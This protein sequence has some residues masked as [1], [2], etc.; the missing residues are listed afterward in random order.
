MALNPSGPISLGGATTGQSI[1]LELA[2]SPTGVI[3]LNQTDVRTLAGAASGTIS[4][5][6]FYGKSS[7]V[8]LYLR[9][10]SASSMAISPDKSRI[11]YFTTPTTTT[12]AVYVFNTSDFSLVYAKTATLHIITATGSQGIYGVT[13]AFDDSNNLFLAKGTYNGG[14]GISFVLYNS[15]G[16]LVASRSISNTGTNGVST[17][18]YANGFFYTAGRINNQGRL[19]KSSS[20]TLALSA[21][22]L[23][24]R[25]RVH[26][27][28]VAS[29]DRAYSIID[30]SGGFINN[31]AVTTLSNNSTVYKKQVPA[32]Q[33]NATYEGG[34][35]SG[36]SLS[37]MAGNY[38]IEERME[39]DYVI[40]SGFSGPTT[41]GLTNPKPY[42]FITNISST[43]T[44]VSCYAI[45]HDSLAALKQSTQIAGTWPFNFGPPFWTNN[46]LVSALRDNLIVIFGNDYFYDMFE[47]TYA[48]TGVHIT[49]F[50]T[51]TNQVIAS[52]IT[53]SSNQYGGA[54]SVLDVIGISVG[55]AQ[56][57]SPTLQITNEYLYLGKYITQTPQSSS[58][59]VTALNAIGGG[60]TWTA[61][62]TTVSSVSVTT[63]SPTLNVQTTSGTERTY[64][65]G[66]TAYTPTPSITEQ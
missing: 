18:F 25:R 39:G 14:N 7:S 42:T 20:S 62:T 23:K 59:L 6:T 58:A 21:E 43:N 65:S 55:G 32:P 61:A 52:A 27:S 64:T 46:S 9:S 54:P 56:S 63:T 51:L 44:V 38:L 36:A 33:Y 13:G 40:G 11:A 53:P 60:I 22:L 5:D 49:I 57:Y 28:F 4:L 47:G 2:L 15:I 3:S 50:N 17:A 48:Y 29:E 41:E 45:H 66:I 8:P 30:E 12:M 37:W 19:I 24:T 10:G 16:T 35:P 26:T 1:A 34:I 31:V